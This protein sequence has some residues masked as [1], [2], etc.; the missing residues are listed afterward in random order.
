V[1]GDTLIFRLDLMDQIRRGIVSM[2][3]YAFVGD[4]IV[5]E[6][7]FMAQVVKNK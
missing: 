4:K 5:T 3:G 2:K 7:E 6:A 1:P